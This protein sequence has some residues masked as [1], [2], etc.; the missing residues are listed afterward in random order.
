MKTVQ[1]LVN[2]TIFQHCMSIFQEMLNSEDYAKS[3]GFHCVLGK[4]GKIKEAK[5]KII[6]LVTEGMLKIF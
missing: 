6:E 2:T 1:T 5:S 3:T 4:F